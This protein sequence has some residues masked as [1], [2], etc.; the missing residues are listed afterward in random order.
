MKMS[1]G[2]VIAVLQAVRDIKNIIEATF[3]FSGECQG[4]KE[5]CEAIDKILDGNT[6]FENTEEFTTLRTA[7][8]DALSYLKDCRKRQFVRNP[9]FE[10]LFHSRIEKYTRIMNDWIV[11][12][13]LS[14]D[15]RI[16]RALTESNTIVSETRHVSKQ[17]LGVLKR[18]EEKMTDFTFL[19][20]RVQRLGVEDHRYSNPAA[21]SE[22]WKNVPV[23][24]PEDV[25]IPKQPDGHEEF[26]GSLRTGDAIRFVPLERNKIDTPR[27]LVVYGEI[28]RSVGIQRLFGIYSGCFG[29]YAV[30]EDLEV[31]VVL[32]D[33][34][35]NVD[36]KIKMIDPLARL[37]LCL[38][39]ATCIAYLHS[40]D[41]IVKVISD[42]SVYIRNVTG[43]LVPILVNLQH[44][45]LVT[46][47]LI[48]ENNNIA[49]FVFRQLFLR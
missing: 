10:V 38:D 49:S 46:S 5:K 30:M 35:A 41:L 29:D 17:T 37:K 36:T 32:Q 8:S 1:V 26:I 42:S 27:L 11:I 23:I 39:L 2:D 40:I 31:E 12:A 18:M 34:L 24:A 16:E 21:R 22:L 19:A 15:V 9:L 20:E 3:A 48:V 4:L 14:V 28:S 25:E 13:I 43:N 6:S 45:R 47:L 7:V 44:A 33:I